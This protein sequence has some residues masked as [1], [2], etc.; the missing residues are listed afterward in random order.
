M[1]SAAVI[2]AVGLV[3]SL[4]PEGVRPL[5]AWTADHLFGFQAIRA[6]ARFAVVLMLGL[7][8]LAGVGVAQARLKAFLVALLTAVM[9]LEYANAPLALDQTE[10]VNLRNL[11]AEDACA[12][13]FEPVVTPNLPVGKVTAADAPTAPR[14]QNPQLF[15]D[16]GAF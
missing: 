14:S 15:P 5:Y 11:T 4:G 1:V 16:H 12:A 3:L 2:A 10:V 7:C 9:C 6:P 13:L 8:V